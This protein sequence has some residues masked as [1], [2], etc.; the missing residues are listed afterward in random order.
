M[1]S[2]KTGKDWSVTT[3]DDLPLNVDSL[4]RQDMEGDGLYDTS[5]NTHWL[6]ILDHGKGYN[7]IPAVQSKVPLAF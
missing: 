1:T 6:T 7:F 5:R 4:R 3:R 2:W